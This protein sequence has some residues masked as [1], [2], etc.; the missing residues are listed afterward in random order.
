[1]HPHTHETLRVLA[2]LYCISTNRMIERCLNLAII[3]LA[4]SAYFSPAKGGQNE[5][6]I[7]LPPIKEEYYTFLWDCHDD[8][9]RLTDPKFEPNAPS[10][11]RR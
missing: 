3:E 7:D 5:W 9:S 8:R 4:N 10:K 6:P 1:M 11:L 2:D